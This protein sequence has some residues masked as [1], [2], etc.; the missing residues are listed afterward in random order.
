MFIEFRM[1][2]F[3]NSWFCTFLKGQSRWIYLKKI[4]SII[5]RGANISAANRLSSYIG[6]HYLWSFVIYFSN[7]LALIMIT[8]GKHGH[9]LRSHENDCECFRKK[10]WE[11]LHIEHMEKVS[12]EDK[13][14]FP[15]FKTFFRAKI[16]GGL[17]LPKLMKFW[18]KEQPLTPP[19]PPPPTRPGPFLGKIYCNFFSR[20][21]WTKFPFFITKI[22][23]PPN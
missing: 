8:V 13:P 20:N 22:S 16:K 17:S 14:E 9:F 7:Q 6:D 1:S 11:K 2:G 4:I 5:W 15:K 12:K 21:S 19:D 18:R 23:T 3:A 10:T